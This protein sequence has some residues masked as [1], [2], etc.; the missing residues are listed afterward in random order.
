MTSTRSI[1]GSWDLSPIQINTGIDPCSAP[2]IAIGP[3][4]NT[5]AVWTKA[6]SGNYSIQ[7]ATKIGSLWT[8]ASVSQ[9]DST[10]ETAINKIAIDGSGNTTIAWAWSASPS[11]RSIKA[12]TKDSGQTTWGPEQIVFTSD[13]SLVLQQAAVDSTGNAT[14]SWKSISTSGARA[15]TTIQVST[16]KSTDIEWQ[17]PT[18]FSSDSYNDFSPQL[19]M[20]AAGFTVL[21]W[22]IDTI[23]ASGLLSTYTVPLLPPAITSVTPN[24]GLPQGGESVTIFGQRFFGVTTVYFGP[25]PASIL[26]INIPSSITVT[27]PPGTGTVHVM[28]GTE[29]GTTS[30]TD[31]DQYSYL[32]NPAVPRHCRGTIKK[33]KSRHHKYLLN[34]KWEGAASPNTLSYRVYKRSTIVGIFSPGIAFR[35][36]S[37][38]KRRSSAKKF[39]IASVTSN[40]VE[41][42]RQKVKIKK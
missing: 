36:E 30:P 39:R 10:T 35:F 1:A 15:S 19:A 24:T 22:K 6:S 21:V 38:L 34:A 41:S 17:P 12:A 29:T 14:V 9:V 5:T 20:N 8:Q 32:S 25:N 16:K 27:T 7:S 23:H 18:T 37:S 2:Q 11:N 33:K 4:G 31:E 42:A 28:V 3:D 26:S 40:N 13:L